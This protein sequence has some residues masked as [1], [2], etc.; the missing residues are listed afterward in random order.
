MPDGLGITWSLAVEE[1][2]YI[3]FP[4]LALLLLRFRR[5]ASVIPLVVLCRRDSCVALLVGRRTAHRKDRIYM[6]TD[7]RIDAIL[8]GLA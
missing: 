8:T 3:V 2:F 7:T 1:H 6:A 5:A 4:V